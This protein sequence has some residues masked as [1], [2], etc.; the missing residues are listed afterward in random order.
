MSPLLCRKNALAHK[1]VQFISMHCT[2]RPSQT[3]GWLS[4]EGY[5]TKYPSVSV[6]AAHYKNADDAFKSK[7]NPATKNLIH[8]DLFTLSVFC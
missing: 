3:N 5:L 6:R 2:V 8:I 7:E 1:Q 4:V